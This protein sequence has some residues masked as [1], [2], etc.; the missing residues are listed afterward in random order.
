VLYWTAIEI[1]RAGRRLAGGVAQ[2]NKDRAF[3]AGED[4][5]SLVHV[6]AIIRISSQ[7][8][9]RLRHH[10]TLSASGNGCDRS[11]EPTT[12]QEKQEYHHCCQQ[13]TMSVI[14]RLRRSHSVDN[15][16]RTTEDGRTDAGDQRISDP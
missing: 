3:S 8:Y 14:N 10:S 16:G 9:V 6:R 11:D 15:T 2:W 13:R 5:R 12:R 1:Q 4:W 7:K